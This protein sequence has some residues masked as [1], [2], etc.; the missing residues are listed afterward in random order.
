M[1]VHIDGRQYQVH[2]VFSPPKN[3]AAF[4]IGATNDYLGVTAASRL[5][6]DRA[7]AALIAQLSSSHP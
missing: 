1:E 6:L 4:A 5:A 3:V 7:N 2:S